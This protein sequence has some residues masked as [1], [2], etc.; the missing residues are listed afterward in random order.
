[1]HKLLLISA[2][3]FIVSSNALAADIGVTFEWGPTKKCF[4]SKSPPIKLSNVP[5]GT[6][7][8]LIKMIDQ[9]ASSFDHGGGSVAFK[10]QSQLPYGAFK[11]K[12]PCPPS[13]THFY[14]ITVKAVDASGKTLG[15]GSAT[16]PFAKK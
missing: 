16:Q 7:K 6:A 11:Y 13:G 8:L 5:Q 4:D 12:G 3:T 10:G 14:K 2:A 9:N 1:M 15:S